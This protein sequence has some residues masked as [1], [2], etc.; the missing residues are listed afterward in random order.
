MIIAEFPVSENVSSKEYT[1][2][3]DA[4]SKE[5]DSSQPYDVSVGEGQSVEADESVGEDSI[6]SDG[7]SY[8]NDSS[9]NRQ[10]R[11]KAFTNQLNCAC[12]IT[13]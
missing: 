8:K 9:T 12:L 11:G 1:S 2:K 3:V 7:L 5:F 13:Q 6:Q 4:S 10:E